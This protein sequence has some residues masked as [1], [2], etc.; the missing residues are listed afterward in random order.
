MDLHDK[1]SGAKPV[2]HNFAQVLGRS[3]VDVCKPAFVQV[4]GPAIDHVAGEDTGFAAMATHLFD[5]AEKSSPRLNLGLF[6]F[7]FPRAFVYKFCD[8][9][10]RRQFD[11][12]QFDPGMGRPH[13]V[14]QP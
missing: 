14:Y 10:I 2:L 12:R 11:F 1:W 7:L 3:R 4:R 13:Q 9:F 8:D 6:Q 5:A